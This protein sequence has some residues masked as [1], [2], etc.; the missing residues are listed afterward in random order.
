MYAAIAG[1]CAGS[2]RL[3]SSAVIRSASSVVLGGWAS[4]AAIPYFRA[5]SV[6]ATAAFYRDPGSPTNTDFGTQEFA[7]TE[8][9]G[10]LLV[11]RRV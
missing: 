5:H 2:A 7:V 4:M 6:D 11:F 10:N 3:S 8:L 1:A 9:D